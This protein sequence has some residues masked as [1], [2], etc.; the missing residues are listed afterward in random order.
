VDF[1]R[2][3]TPP[4]NER[5]IVCEPRRFFSLARVFCRYGSG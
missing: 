1:S 4:L 5:K 2:V 3:S